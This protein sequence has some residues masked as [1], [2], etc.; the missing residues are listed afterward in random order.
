MGDD[1]EIDHR[2]TPVRR[3]RSW[4]GGTP[5]GQERTVSYESEDRYWTDYLRV[6]LPVIGLLLMLALFWWWAQQ[7]I[8]DDGDPDDVALATQTNI[9]T[10]P[11]PTPT[12]TVEV[13]VQPTESDNETSTPDDGSGGENGG[14]G[15]DETPSNGE[16]TQNCEFSEG[17][18]VR[19]AEENVRLRTDPVVDADNIIVESI[20]QEN[21]LRILADCFEEDGEGNEFWF[22]RDQ[23]TSQTGY[24]AGEFL[25]AAEE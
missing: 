24:V 16:Q 3:S 9:A 5:V 14:S 25:V 11:A 18:I 1:S 12:N 13:V 4:D 8:G 10:L 19:V 22:V 17:Q 2:G 6:A 20:S 15:E 23:N 21:D 7:F